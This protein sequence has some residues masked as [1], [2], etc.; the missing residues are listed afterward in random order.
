M[1]LTPAQREAIGARGNVLV[2]A[3]AGTGKTSTLVERCLRCLLEEKP[4][5]SLDEI[6]MV[7]FTDAAAAEMRQRIRRRLEEE[8]NSGDLYRAEQL[9][10]FDT[11]HIGT[12]HSF[13]LRLVRQHFYEL[14][15][16]P[17]FSV[18][19]EEEARLQADDTLGKLLQE[20]YA[21]KS[22]NAEAVQRLIQTQGRGWDVPIRELVLR[23]HHYSQTL[24]DPEGWLRDQI[25]LFQSPD[26]APWLEWL[27]EGARDWR[28][29]WLPLLEN[30]PKARECAAILKKLPAQPSRASLATALEEIRQADQD[31]PRGEK[32]A[33]RKPLEDFFGEAVF[34]SS[35]AGAAENG[36]PLAEDWEWV[37]GGMATLLEL[38]REFTAA[39]NHAKRELGVIDFHDLEQHALALLWN[40]ASQQ[41]T[42]TARKWRDKLR[43]I[44]VDEYQDINAAQDKIIQ[45]LSRD[46][47][48]A[49][50]F[51]VGDVKQSIYRFRLADPR[52]FQEY[53]RLWRGG[54]GKTIALTDN[55]RSREALLDFINSLFAAIMRPEMGGVAYDEEARLR[56]GNPKD[57]GPLSVAADGGA[58]AELHLRVKGRGDDLP[59]GDEES[60]RA[61]REIENLEEAGKEARLA[62][63][64]L[65]ELK[66]EGHLI[67]DERAKALRP[68]EWRDMV[69]LLRSP[70]GKA[71]SYAKEFTRLNVPLQVARGGFYESTEVSDLLSLLQALDNPLQDIP[72][73]AVLRSPLVGLSLNELAATR[74]AVPKGPFWIALQKLHATGKNQAGLDKIARFLENFAKWRRMARQVSLSHC[75]EAVLAETHYA[76]WVLTQAR[77]SQRHANVQRLVAL[78]QQFDQFQRQ[79]LFRFLRFIEAQRASEAEPDVAAIGGED[80]VSLMSIHQSKGLE[81][82]VVVVADLG[83]PFNLSDLRADIILDEKYGLCPQIKPPR[84]G[85]RY[86]SLPYWLAH[87]RQKQEALGEE[88]RLLYVALTRARDTL[89]LTGTVSE[90]KLAA[91]WQP[92]GE[93][94]SASLLAARNYLDWIGAWFSKVMGKSLSAPTGETGWLRWTI[95]DGMDGR[96]LE[97]GDETGATGDTRRS[98]ADAETREALQNRLAWQY[99]PLAAT[100]EPAK[101]SVSAL[102]RRAADE[103]SAL[104]E[105]QGS[106]FKVQSSKPR[107]QPRKGG[108]N[109]RLSATEIGTAHHDFL[110]RVSLERVGGLADLRQETERLAREG[111]LSEQE[112]ERLDLA[113][114]LAFW[115]SEIGRRIQGRAAHVHRELAFTARFTPREL[116]EFTGVTA[117]PAGA[118]EDEFVVVQGVADLVVLLPEEIWLLDFK[119]DEISGD[120]LSSRVKLHGPQLQLYA[121]ALERIYQRPV[122]EKWLHFLALRESVTP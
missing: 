23:L 43:F 19:A 89:I 79:G 97:M 112:I 17:Q 35:L 80:A 63:L 51:L 15:L 77:G 40:R 46:G 70:A 55:F 37:R 61:W 98:R 50:R 41:P 10:L 113:A 74:L 67:W 64:R 78:A 26:P 60:T 110:Q 24:P 7:T 90:N 16:D 30:S 84:T 47:P 5:A 38:S 101:T 107:I 85:R 33:L 12:L 94:T 93:L 62:A 108:S 21:G 87:R 99:P 49:N 13:C 6:L 91:H 69:I 58:R 95:Y 36:D 120:E 122:T 65:R 28:D 82:P 14:E 1:S 22:P 31:W 96:M 73:L 116:R 56:F 48:G 11:A 53:A 104:F 115:Q 121:A 25:A 103:M 75:L 9:A 83:K 114:L 32:T 81:F 72:L 2:V 111:V 88:L 100:R 18:M 54:E 71:E 102:R 86:P 76:A 105:V 66:T 68:V 39:F 3:G 27:L 118:L 8:A 109:A 45:A 29:R 119:T 42:G 34:L 106:K 59:E 92:D 117:L 4:P 44:F 20:H 52:I 57:R